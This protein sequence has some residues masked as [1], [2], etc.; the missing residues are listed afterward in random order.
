MGEHAEEGQDDKKK[1]KFKRTDLQVDVSLMAGLTAQEIQ[2]FN[3][4]EVEMSNQDRVV[5]ETAEK[6]NE[7]ESYVYETRNSIQNEL[8]D[9]IRS[10]IADQFV[11]TLNETE[12]WL[13][14]DEGSSCQKSEYVR[15]LKELKAIGDAAVRRKFEHENRERAVGQLKA[16]VTRY[17][18]SVG[19]DPKYSH[20]E[21]SEKDR[22]LAFCNQ[23]EDWLTQVQAQQDR[24]P[25]SE[26]PVFTC[27]SLEKKRREIENLADP[28]LSK[29]KPQPAPQPAQPAQ[30]A[31][32]AQP[33]P[34]PAP[35]ASANSQQ[36]AKM[37]VEN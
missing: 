6:R 20:I 22:I 34:Q 12:D 3:E 1:K 13:L 5:A 36:E 35:E 2:R 37:D 33:Q 18:T 27:D 8:K 31:A 9:Y 25:L 14:T 10:D 30:P 29:P 19:S 16:T 21:Q 11:N 17:Q 24:V 23:T 26:D 15:R 28:I 7:L 32:D 4:V